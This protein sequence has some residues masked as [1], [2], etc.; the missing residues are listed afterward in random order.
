MESPGYLKLQRKHM[1]SK[2]P[3]LNPVTNIVLDL[4]TENDK[5]FVA[6]E[7]GA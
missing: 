4:I 1:E 2:V 5:G 3:R 6:V 7:I